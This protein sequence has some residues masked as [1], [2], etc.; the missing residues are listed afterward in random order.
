MGII[1]A[2]ASEV[3]EKKLYQPY[4]PH[5]ISHHLGLDTH[6]AYPL[7]FAKNGRA[8][9]PKKHRLQAG[10][11][12]TI[13]PGLYFP[14]NDKS[15]PKAFSGLGVRLEESVLITPKGHEILSRG[16]PIERQDVECLC[17]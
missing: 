6:D 13:E 15:V 16:V 12:I 17:S 11:V 1:K 4:F 8:I 5:S 9:N 14:S 3:N 10:N 7:T 2:S